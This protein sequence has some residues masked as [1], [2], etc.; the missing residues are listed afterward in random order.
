MQKKTI[1]AS[2][3]PL[4]SAVTFLALFQKP[5]WKNRI[6]IHSYSLRGR[7]W[8]QWICDYRRIPLL[9]FFNVFDSAL[10]CR[11][12]NIFMHVVWFVRVFSNNVVFALFDVIDVLVVVLPIGIQ[13]DRLSRSWASQTSSR[14]YVFL[15]LWLSCGITLFGQWTPRDQKG[16]RVGVIKAWDFHV[17]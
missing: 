14:K 3:G 4:R 1:Q 8:W 11:P 6:K 2:A 13:C 17:P 10:D 15:W 16:K 7:P 12:K 9:C 5:T